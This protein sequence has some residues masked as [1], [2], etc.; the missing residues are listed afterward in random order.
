M[1]RGVAAAAVVMAALAACG[2][3]AADQKVIDGLSKLDVMA[4][5]PGAIELSRTS[6][7]GG[8]NSVIRNSS[9]VTLVYGTTQSPFEVKHDFHARFDSTWRLHDNGAAPLGGW[10]ASGRSTT[11]PDAVATVEARRVTSAD[12]APRDVQSVVTVEASATRPA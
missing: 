3:D 12:K 8:G 10:A 7:K 11:D 4:M 1:W 9:S 5:P 6:H 2:T